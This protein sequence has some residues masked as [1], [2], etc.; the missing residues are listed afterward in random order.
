MIIKLITEKEN[1]FENREKI[2]LNLGGILLHCWIFTMKYCKCSVWLT[3]FTG[4]KSG[5]A[6]F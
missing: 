5:G 4:N 1:A 3:E 2:E 6:K